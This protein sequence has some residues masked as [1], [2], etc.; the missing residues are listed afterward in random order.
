MILDRIMHAVPGYYP[1]HL[2]DR[3][4]AVHPFIHVK[5]GRVAGFQLFKGERVADAGLGG[6]AGVFVNRDVVSSYPE[7]RPAGLGPLSP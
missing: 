4:T 3:V 2:F 6:F 7:T 1:H 5:A